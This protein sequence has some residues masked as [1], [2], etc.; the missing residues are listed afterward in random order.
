MI[1]FLPVPFYDLVF[2]FLSFFLFF[3]SRSG[4]PDVKQPRYGFVLFLLL[5]FWVGNKKNAPFAQTFP[6]QLFYINP[7]FSTQCSFY[8]P[9]ITTYPSIPSLSFHAPHPPNPHLVDFA[10]SVTLLSCTL[11][12]LLKT[13]LWPELSRRKVMLFFFFCLFEMICCEMSSIAEMSLLRLTE[14]KD[15]CLCPEC[16]EFVETSL[17][18]FSLFGIIRQCIAIFPSLPIVHS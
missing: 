7:S 1:F 6:P 16:T 15:E 2:S 9:P 3:P 4:A 11:A 18:S 17:L 8:L 10:L 14:Q 12:F 13:R 5:F